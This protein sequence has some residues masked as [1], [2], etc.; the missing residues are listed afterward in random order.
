MTTNVL[1]Y[2]GM[3]T[4][5]GSY[6]TLMYGIMKRQQNGPA[7]VQ[8]AEATTPQLEVVMPVQYTPSDRA[9]FWAKVNKTPT[10]WLWTGKPNTKGYGRFGINYRIVAAHRFAWEITN[11]PIPDGLAVLHRCDNPPCCNP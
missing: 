2:G 3:F 1:N 8:T 11:G 6:K 5:S 9:R 4:A 7:L 10:C